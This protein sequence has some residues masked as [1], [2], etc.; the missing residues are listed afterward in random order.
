M[1]KKYNISPLLLAFALLLLPSQRL[2][3]QD[4]DTLLVPWL[5][6]V[7]DELLINSLYEAIVS[8][9]TDTG[10]RA[11]LDRVYKLEQGGF[12]YNTERIENSNFPLRI[13][14][15]PGD[16]SDMFA[17]PPMIQLEHRD[18]GNRTDKIL[19]GG[20]DVTLKNLIIN[21]KTTL[22]DLPYEI[23]RFDGEEAEIVIDNVVFEYAAWGIMAVYGANSKVH[24]TNSVFRNLLSTTQL[25]GGRGM[26]IWTDMQEVRIE[27]NTFMN[28]GGFAIQIEGGVANDL[29][30]NHNTFVNIGRQSILHSWHVNSHITNNLFVNSW[31]HGE[32]EE[33]FSTLR[34]EEEDNQFSGD[35]F[36]NE[37]PTRYGLDIERVIVVSNNSH[38]RDSFFED[39]YASTANDDFPLRS[40]PFVNVRTQNYADEYENII[41]QNT[42]SELDPGIQ[43]MPDNLQEMVNFVNA[44]R[45]DSEVI[46]MYYWDP[47][48]EDDNYSIQWPLPEDL[49]YT[50]TTHQ[51]AAFGGFPLGDLNWFPAEKAAWM[52][53]KDALEA[54]IRDLSGDAP[55]IVYVDKVEAEDGV[56]LGNAEVVQAEDLQ[57]VRIE[58][59]GNPTFMFDM[60]G[61]HTL[62]VV[63]KK[64]S[65]WET[66]NE[67]RATNLIVNDGEAIAVPAG[68][69]TV[70]GEPYDWAVPRV[71]EVDFV[72]G[73]NTLVLGHNWGFIEY[74][75][76]TLL[77]GET[78]VKTLFAS[79]AELVGGGSISCGGDNCASGDHYVDL[80]DGGLQIGL[81]LETGGSHILILTYKLLEQGVASADLTV[82]NQ[83][84]QQISFE[85]D[86]GAFRTVAFDG[87]EMNQGNNTIEIDDVNG[88]VALDFVEIFRVGTPTSARALELPEGFTLGQ[89]Y[90]NPFNPTTSI[91]F[92]LPYTAD[93][94]LQV[95]NILGQRVATLAEGSFNSGTHTVNF[96]ASRLSSGVYL[97]R[98]NTGSHTAVRKMML[99]K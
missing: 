64:R 98:L 38:Y 35:I 16:P 39:F 24:I 95:Y 7:T 19:V 4:A 73:S 86:A 57:L 10:E 13:V 75:R 46:P 89:N 51:S 50:N 23:V 65:W 5:D 9:T 48:R 1:K 32:G 68:T 55:D 40:Q 3:G 30:I 99:V 42:F 31:W 52:Q 62:D 67:E 80:T 15:E 59:S 25:W 49:S 33:G 63:I 61:A 82:N 71:S 93:V 87:L 6:P 12:Y 18:D 91:H 17:N 96:D 37:L 79:Q 34:L 97:Y 77:D 11:N 88:S 54:E 92:T 28:I 26:S 83:Y 69:E 36:I 44:I 74:E 47:G 94:T 20:H 70:P 8:D 72:E 22:G 60:D 81:D 27:N 43:T 14:G 41:I 84:I 90:P 21:G 2:L 85:G 66:I 78:E 76:V 53:Q 56:L 58:G 45:D 29:W